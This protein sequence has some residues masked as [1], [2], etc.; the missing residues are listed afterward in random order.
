MI[1]KIGET[2]KALEEYMEEYEPPKESYGVFIARSWYNCSEFDQYTVDEIYRKHLTGERYRSLFISGEILFMAEY[3]VMAWSDHHPA[4]VTEVT[5]VENPE[6]EIGM[7]AIP[8]K[9]WNTDGLSPEEYLQR[10]IK[11]YR[12][13][14]M[15]ESAC[16]YQ[17]FFGHSGEFNLSVAV[18]RNKKEQKYCFLKYFHYPEWSTGNELRVDKVSDL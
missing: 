1:K 7:L 18:L 10:E 13:V 12:T 11:K 8:L 14:N 9:E 5:D 16:V 15:G 2:L 6:S 17:R 4:W 3:T